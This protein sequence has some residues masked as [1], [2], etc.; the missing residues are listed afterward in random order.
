VA[1]KAVGER[2][3]QL[4]VQ[5]LDV[6]PESLQHE[7]VVAALDRTAPNGRVEA[8]P[9]FV[10]LHQCRSR[11]V[12]GN[13]GDRQRDA[14]LVPW[15]QPAQE[16]VMDDRQVGRAALVGSLHVPAA[17][18][19]EFVAPGREGRMEVQGRQPT[20]RAERDSEQARCRGRIQEFENRPVRQA[21]RNCLPQERREA[22]AVAR[23]LTGSAGAASPHP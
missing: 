18:Q 17:A 1:K 16:Y 19:Q 3:T 6:G 14:G 20:Q 11:V 8:E 7:Q 9:V 13:A 4:L 21:F 5:M 15:H 23:E 2:R 10:E 22:L 12:I